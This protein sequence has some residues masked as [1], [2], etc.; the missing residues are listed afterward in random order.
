MK[1]EKRLF[2]IVASA[3]GLFVLW[4]VFLV[5]ADTYQT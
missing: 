5:I 3:I 1:L 2:D 4:P